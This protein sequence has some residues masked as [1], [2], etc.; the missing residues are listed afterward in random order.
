LFNNCNYA[1]TLSQIFMKNSSIC[2][3]RNLVLKGPIINKVQMHR[4][5]KIIQETY[6][7]KNMPGTYL[8]KIIPET[9]L[10]K[11]ITETYLVKII[12]ETYLVDT[13]LA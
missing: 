7:V 1:L 5:V 6:L 11:I 9:Y 2:E 10:V 3:I 4:G 8:V 13:F 12:P